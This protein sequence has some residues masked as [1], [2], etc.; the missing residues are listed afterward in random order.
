ML[1]HL[2]TFMYSKSFKQSFQCTLKISDLLRTLPGL[3]SCSFLKLFIQ[4]FH[5]N[6][7]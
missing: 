2:Y 6:R 7:L 3:F 4:L 1:T 5:V